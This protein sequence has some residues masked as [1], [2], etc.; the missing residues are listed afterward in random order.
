MSFQKA[1][2]PKYSR[3]HLV[4]HTPKTTYHLY[5]YRFTEETLEGSLKSLTDEKKVGLHVYTNLDF[6]IGLDKDSILQITIPKSNIE[7]VKFHSLNIWKTALLAFL[8]SDGI[9]TLYVVTM[10]MVYGL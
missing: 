4:L 2:E 6:E 5:D 8:V 1:S 10:I 7:T 3:D 9:L